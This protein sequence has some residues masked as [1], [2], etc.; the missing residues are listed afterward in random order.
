MFEYLK[1]VIRHKW[2]VLL[3]GLEL[4]VPLY[5]L[6]THDLS[7]LTPSEYIHYQR[8]FFVDKCDP[9]GFSAA[10]LHH[11]NHNPHHWDYWLSRTKG[12]EQS[13]EVEI[14]PI[15]MP[16][17]YVRELVVDW[18]AAGK[19]YNNALPLQKWL[20]KEWKNMILHPLTVRRVS[21]ILQEIGMYWPGD[22]E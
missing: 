2:Y 4:N 12:S 1:V 10:W 5:Q 21:S 11:Q 18:L 16:E 17:K 3:Y 9:D 8:W 22:V 7:K 20:N 19:A 15:P 13:R 14:K 6:I